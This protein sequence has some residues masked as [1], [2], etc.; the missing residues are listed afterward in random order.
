MQRYQA[1]NAIT[2]KSTTS[3]SKI[4]EA[5]QNYLRELPDQFEGDPLTEGEFKN[6][7]C[8]ERL[9]E[10]KDPKILAHVEEYR[11]TRTKD[12]KDKAMNRKM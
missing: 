9:R 5:Y 10:E 1:Y 12:D 7:F 11:V 2:K 4:K 3:S 8:M 6:Q